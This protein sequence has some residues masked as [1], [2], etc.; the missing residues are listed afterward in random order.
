M[1]GVDVEQILPRENRNDTTL[2]D[3]EAALSTRFYSRSPVFLDD[4]S[5]TTFNG[6]M[7]IKNSGVYSLTQAPHLS[8]LSTVPTDKVDKAAFISERARGAYIAAVC[9][10]DLTFG[11]SIFSQYPDPDTIA[12]KRL[13]KVVTYAKANSDVALKF[14]KLHPTTIKLSVFSY[15]SF[16]AN[17]D[18]SSQLA[19]VITL[20]DDTG[21]ANILHYSSTKSRRVTRS[22]LSSELFAAVHAFDYASTIRTTLCDV[23]DQNVPLTLYTDSKCLFDGIMGFNATSEK[24]LLIDLRM[25]REAY[26][27]REIAEVIWIPSGENPADAMTKDAPCAAMH[28]L[29]ANNALDLNFISWVKRQGYSKAIWTTLSATKPRNHEEGRVSV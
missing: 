26:E 7:V 19:Y 14:V 6:S 27:M 28:K 13:N 5:P 23:F 15:A 12:A 1:S 11:F 16:A 9:R 29:M 20:S 10:P 4:G 8:K 24:R 17:P 18:S 21:R 25:L 3:K 2:Y 22:V